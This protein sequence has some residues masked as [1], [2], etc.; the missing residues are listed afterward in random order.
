VLAYD[1]RSQFE[2]LAREAGADVADIPRL[3]RLINDV[4]AEVEGDPGCGARSAC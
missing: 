2:E 3:K 4:V 1:H